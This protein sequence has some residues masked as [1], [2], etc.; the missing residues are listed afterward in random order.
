MKENCQICGVYDERPCRSVS[1]TL[2]CDVLLG[3]LRDMNAFEEARDILGSLVDAARAE[4]R[5]LVAQTFDAVLNAR[6]RRTA[7]LLDWLSDDVCLRI[8]N[9]L[10][11]CEDAAFAN[12]ENLSD[13]LGL[14]DEARI[15]ME[16]ALD[17]GKEEAS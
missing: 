4:E 10:A 15:R 17:R 9:A 12:D 6:R 13:L 14:L 8:R 16:A 11:G 7:E 1:E 2:R 3:E 5:E